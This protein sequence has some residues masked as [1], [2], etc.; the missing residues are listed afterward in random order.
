MDGRRRFGNL[1]VHQLSRDPLQEGSAHLIFLTER[2]QAIGPDAGL[3]FLDDHFAEEHIVNLALQG[4]VVVRDGT[5][6]DEIDHE[7]E[8]LVAVLEHIVKL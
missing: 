2:S 6:E 3:Q 4:L 7:Q 1:C 8:V 5:R